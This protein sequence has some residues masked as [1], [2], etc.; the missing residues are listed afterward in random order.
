[1]KKRFLWIAYLG[2]GALG[3]LAY[4][5]L[6]PVAKSGPFFNLLGLSSVVAITIGIRLH[7][8]PDRQ[9]FRA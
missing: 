5:A 2:L 4:Y 3:G 8:P 1:M 9:I 7:R 6:P